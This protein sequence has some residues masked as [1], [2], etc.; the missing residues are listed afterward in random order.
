MNNFCFFFTRI[1]SNTFR[2]FFQIIFLRFNVNKIVRYSAEQMRCRSRIY[3]AQNHTGSVRNGLCFK[4]E[5]V[6]SYG[7]TRNVGVAFRWIRI[8]F[9]TKTTHLG[10]HAT[11]KK[12][13]TN[14]RKS[15]LSFL[16]EVRK[17]GLF[18]ISIIVFRRPVCGLDEKRPEQCV[19]PRYNLSTLCLPYSPSNNV[20]RKTNEHCSVRIRYWLCS[21][22]N[23]NSDNGVKNHCCKS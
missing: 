11:N 15:I 2:I 8:L 13:R 14:R 20:S 22:K 3:S 10:Q 4:R 18:C 17:P 1:R 21:G 16:T 12:P 7:R 9:G 6:K 23:N 19:L 5:K